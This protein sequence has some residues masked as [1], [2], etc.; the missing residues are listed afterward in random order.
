MCSIASRPRAITKGSRMPK[1]VVT[2]A[3]EDIDRWLQ[4]KEARAAAIESGTGSNVTDY[5]AADGS[6][7]IAVTADV[8]DVAAIQQMLASPSPEV[9]AAMKAPW[10]RPTAHCVHPEVGTSVPVTARR[11]ATAGLRFHGLLPRRYPATR[12]PAHEHFARARPFRDAEERERRCGTRLLRSGSVTPP[13]TNQLTRGRSEWCA[14]PGEE[15][16]KPGCAGP[17]SMERIGIEP[18][19][20]GLQILSAADQAWS[21]CVNPRRLRDSAP[22]CTSRGSHGGQPDLTRI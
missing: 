15:N 11:P 14:V 4:G 21:A 19:T 10:R 8:A 3:V 20:S 18:M 12:A 7:N 6:N 16:K 1:V 13:L 17:F 5:V 22:R 9:Q 2:H